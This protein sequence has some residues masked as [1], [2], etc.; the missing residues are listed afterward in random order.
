MQIVG[1]VSLGSARDDGITDVYKR[2]SK[3]T[4][5]GIC[6]LV[7]GALPQYIQAVDRKRSSIKIILGSI[8]I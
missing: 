6:S 8:A 2:Q 7:S 4:L 3:N 5:G 1:R